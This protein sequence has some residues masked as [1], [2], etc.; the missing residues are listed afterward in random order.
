MQVSFKNLYQV[1]SQ[2]SEL[3][4]FY[5]FRTTEIKLERINNRVGGI[6]H[7]KI[8]DLSVGQKEFWGK[9]AKY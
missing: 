2:R 7:F 1:S 9:L 5:L 6:G 4:F 3:Q 8:Q